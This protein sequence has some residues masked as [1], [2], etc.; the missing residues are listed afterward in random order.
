MFRKNTPINPM[1]DQRILVRK[2]HVSSKSTITS[3]IEKIRALA[4]PTQP[5]MNEADTGPFGV[6]IVMIWKLRD[7]SS[8]RM[9]MALVIVTIRDAM[10]GSTYGESAGSASSEAKEVIVVA[11]MR[12]RGVKA[13]F[14]T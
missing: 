6:Y 14:R 1:V 7:L 5:H 3:I 9:P 11:T 8:V 10:F 2:V 4:K 13:S 12:N